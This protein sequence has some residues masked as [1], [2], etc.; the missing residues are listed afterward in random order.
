MDRRNFIGNMAAAPLLMQSSRQPFNIVYLHSHDTGRYIQPYGH[1]V[2]TPNLQKLASESILFR[3]AFSGAPTCSPSRAALLTGQPAHTSGMLGLAHRGFTLHDYNQHLLHTLRPLGY[4]SALCGVQHI[5]RDPKTIGYDEVIPVK[6]MHCANVA[7]AA[8][9]FLKNS[10]KQPFYIEI[11]FQETHRPY[12]EPGPK[13]DVRYSMP[14]PTVPDTPET[15]LDIASFKA[16]ARL[17]DDAVG[18]ILTQLAA[19]G[20]DGNTLVI[21]TTDHGIAFPAMKC[22]LTDQGWGVMLMMRGPGGFSGGKVC[23]A[24][25]SQLDI[26]PTLCEM[27]NLERPAWLTGKSMLPVIRGEAKEIND[28]VY[29]E[30][31]YHAAYEPKRAIRTHRYKY[32]RHFGG[33]KTPVL[34]NCDD[35]PSKSLWLSYDWKNQPVAEERL[36]DLVFDPLEHN[37]LAGDASLKAMLNDLRGRMDGWMKATSDPL[38]KGPVPLPPG[39]VTNDPNG[40]SPQERTKA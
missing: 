3:N 13:E 39:A 36:Y 38:L 16:T 11:G 28:Q 5:A 37:N 23:D 35:G 12:I 40:T 34:P 24:M 30:V 8:V 1:A 2:P 25:I 26:Y 9:N 14:P 17:M 6:N 21:S 7:P 31:T 22:N 15:R 19:S 4:Y 32:I 10:P 29:G 27:L 20:L 33:R 18:T